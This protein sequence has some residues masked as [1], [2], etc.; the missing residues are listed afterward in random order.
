MELKSP[1]PLGEPCDVP[2]Q[3]H[4]RQGFGGGCREGGPTGDDRRTCSDSASSAL[5]RSGLAPVFGAP[6]LPASGR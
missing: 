5:L 6:R 1:D 3:V 2:A 4:C